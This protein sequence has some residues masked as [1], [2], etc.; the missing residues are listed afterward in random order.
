LIGVGILSLVT[1]AFTL[2]P[3]SE[4]PSCLT[5]PTDLVAD[6]LDCRIFYQCDLNPQPMS[7]GDLMFNSVRQVCDWPS[8]VLQLRPECRTEEQIRIGSGNFPYYR[9]LRMLNFFGG[10][11]THSPKQHSRAPQ[12]LERKNHFRITEGK[13]LSLTPVDNRIEPVSNLIKEEEDKAYQE[14]RVQQSAPIRPEISLADFDQQIK[15]QVLKEIRGRLH[16]IVKNSITHQSKPP[17][18]NNKAKIT[19]AD[20]VRLEPVVHTQPIFQRPHPAVV[21]TVTH[22]ESSVQLEPKVKP[23]KQETKVVR[24]QPTPFNALKESKVITQS[25]LEQSREENGDEEKIEVQAESV[26]ADVVKLEPQSPAYEYTVQ[27]I[28]DSHPSKAKLEPQ[29]APILVEDTREFKPVWPVTRE[30]PRQI[31]LKF[32]NRINSSTPCVDKECSGRIQRVL[33][34]IKRKLIAGERQ[35]LGERRKELKYGSKS[36]MNSINGN[37]DEK[38]DGTMDAS[39]DEDLNEDERKA[40]TLKEA[41]DKAINKVEQ[42]KRPVPGNLLHEILNRDFGSDGNINYGEYN[43]QTYV[44]SDELRLA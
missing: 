24:L 43:A 9:T 36:N 1:G 7:C 2:V 5:H 13:K 6:P 16:D 23:P 30:R 11:N 34:K 42:H 33:R 19:P 15:N 10:G 17:L 27:T 28:A 41:Y 8:T 26:P 39:K 18:Q 38:M 29:P 20:T 4:F 31:L 21:K 25:T 14:I 22:S 40:I 44:N 12:E 37:A 3:L 32:R 35:Q